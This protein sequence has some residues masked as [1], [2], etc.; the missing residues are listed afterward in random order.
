LK[1]LFVETVDLDDR[2]LIEDYLPIQAISAETSWG[3]SVRIHDPA[4][5]LDHAKRELP[6]VRFYEVAMEA[7]EK[8][9]VS[10]EG[11]G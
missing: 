6:V 8:A 2:R 1:D 5:N 7:N 9:A 11:M 3:K 10:V 4:T